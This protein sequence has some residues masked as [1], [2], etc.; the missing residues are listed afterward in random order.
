MKQSKWP[1]FLFTIAVRLI[2]GIVPECGTCHLFGHRVILRAL[3]QDNNHGPL[4]W[5]AL[6]G[7][8]GGATAVFTT[9]NWQ[10]PCHKGI[11]GRNDDNT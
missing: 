2:G 5:L 3:S 9:L 8:A 1:H 6:C 10:T 7:R 4:I 11:R